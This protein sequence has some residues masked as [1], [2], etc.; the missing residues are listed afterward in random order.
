MNEKISLCNQNMAM[1]KYAMQYFFSPA[2]VNESIESKS[3]KRENTVQGHG[4]GAIQ[5]VMRPST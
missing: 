2:N 5:Q 1:H 4:K 3:W